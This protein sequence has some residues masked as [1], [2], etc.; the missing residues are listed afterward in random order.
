MA[1]Q[2]FGSRQIKLGTIDAADLS[3]SGAAG[4]TTYLRGDN[5][6]SA[7]TAAPPDISMSLLAPSSNETIPAGYGAYISGYYELVSTFTTEISA[8]SYFEIG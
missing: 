8:G 2:L 5:T 7:V 3:A 6:W 1:T 4:S